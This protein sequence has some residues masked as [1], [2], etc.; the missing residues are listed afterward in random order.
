VVVKT[1]TATVYDADELGC[2]IHT[3]VAG[4][5]F[6]D[7]GGG[8]VHLVANAGTATLEVYAFQIIPHGAPRVVS[9]S[10]PLECPVL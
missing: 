9:E 3:Y 8:H 6:V 4:S 10:Q 2:H 7:S 5:G 1:G